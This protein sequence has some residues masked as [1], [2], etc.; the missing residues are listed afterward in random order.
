MCAEKGINLS[1]K[2]NSNRNKQRQQITR[3]KENPHRQRQ[4]N[5]YATVE[6][7]AETEAGVILRKR[8]MKA[9]KLPKRL[10][11]GCGLD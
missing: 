1:R 10:K 6:R 8:K 5:L 7:R 4:M 11:N 9:S 2:I 3:N